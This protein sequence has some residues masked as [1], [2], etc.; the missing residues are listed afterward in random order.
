MSKGFMWAI[1]VIC[2]VAGIFGGLWAADTHFTPREIH[3]ITNEQQNKEFENAIVQ[4]QQRFIDLQA[5]RKL[6]KARD[7]Y[8]YWSRVTRELQDDCRR[9]PND[10]NLKYKLNRAVDELNKAE[11]YLKTLQGK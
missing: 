5:D 10:Q 7:N 4:V 8:W 9:N 6:E 3:K 2:A 1:G 11:A